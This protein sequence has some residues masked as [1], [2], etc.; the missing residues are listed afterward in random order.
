MQRFNPPKASLSIAARWV[1]HLD[2]LEDVECA[3]LL[4]HHHSQLRINIMQMLQLPCGF[5]LAFRS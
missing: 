1:P 5:L 2:A 4:W 3:F